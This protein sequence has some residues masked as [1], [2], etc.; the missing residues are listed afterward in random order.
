MERLKG[1]TTLPF[2]STLR[3]LHLQVE[4][5]TFE[6]PGKV[7]VEN[8]RAYKDELRKLFLKELLPQL[9]ADE[10]EHCGI[11]PLLL[12]KILKAKRPGAGNKPQNLILSPLKR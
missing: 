9:A 11:I 7:Y 2:H 3:V 5:A 10:D 1:Y 12:D 6:A 4:S 8:E